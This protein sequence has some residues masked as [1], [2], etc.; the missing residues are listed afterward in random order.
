MADMLVRLYDLPSNEKKLE[1]LAAQG[2]QI[3]RA[4]AP[5]KRAI[6]EFVEN[7]V[8]NPRSAGE[9][10]VCFSNT[11]ISLFVAT[12]GSKLIGYACYNATAL[13]F[14]GPT[15]VL[16]EYRGKGIGKALLLQSLHAMYAEGYQYAIIGGVGPREFYEKVCGA[17]M[18]E[19][20][21]PGS[22]KDFLHDL[23]NQGQ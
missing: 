8:G 10:D 19:N 11:P 20:S 9:A 2:I 12:E 15:A 4:M 7:E 1:E 23:K 6:L 3:R 16:E 14:F 5:D 17:V 18:I 21:T 22:Y 13:D